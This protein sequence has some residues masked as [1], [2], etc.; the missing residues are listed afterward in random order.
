MDSLT[1]MMCGSC[2]NE[3]AY[4]NMFM[5][6]QR[7]KRGGTSDFTDLEKESCMI[8]MPPGAPKLSIL[9]FKGSF[10]GR[11]LGVLSTTHSKYVHKLD[12]PAF[13]WPIARFPEYKYPLHENLREN[14]Q[15]DESC[16]AEV[17]TMFY[18]IPIIHYNYKYYNIYTI[19]VGLF[20]KC[21]RPFY[22]SIMQLFKI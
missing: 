10:H 3:N 20:I 18:I 6:Y 5:K 17:S 13:D 15:E 9:S 21:I 7:D 16:L 14:E 11:T 19:Y 12:V 8:N 22:S 1:T 4:K 2:S